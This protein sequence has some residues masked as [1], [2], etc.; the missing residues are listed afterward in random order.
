MWIVLQNI[1][2]GPQDSLGLKFEGL[3]NRKDRVAAYNTILL[4]LVSR[5]IC[6]DVGLQ[7]NISPYGQKRY[8]STQGGHSHLWLFLIW[9]CGGLRLQCC[10]RGGGLLPGHT[11]EN[12]A[13]H[14]DEGK[15]PTANR[16]FI[17]AEK[18]FDLFHTMLTLDCNQ[19]TFTA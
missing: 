14:Q 3:S 7:L 5:L 18:C 9:G 2:V 8:G 15:P 17:V 4:G 12:Y 16:E 6:R 19:D 11:A 10:H 1:V 13:C